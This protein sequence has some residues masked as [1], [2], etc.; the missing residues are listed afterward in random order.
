MGMG[1]GSHDIMTDFLAIGSEPSQPSSH[2]SM[3]DVAPEGN[4]SLSPEES[5]SWEMIGLGLNEPL[6]PQNMIDEL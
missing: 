1:M 2:H 6:P 5:F 3:P 4:L